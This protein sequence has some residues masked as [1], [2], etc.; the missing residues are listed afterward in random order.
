M[1]TDQLHPRRPGNEVFSLNRV[2]CNQEAN[3]KALLFLA[4]Q[5]AGTVETEMSC[6]VVTL[7]AAGVCSR[8]SDTHY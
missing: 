6:L 4:F 8:V 2:A 5:F 1:V 3:R 7:F